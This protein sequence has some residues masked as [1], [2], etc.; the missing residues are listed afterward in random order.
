MFFNGSNSESQNAKW[1]REQKQAN[2]FT[3][4]VLF[5]LVSEPAH[6]YA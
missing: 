6:T 3:K 2:T 1:R 4:R 5:I